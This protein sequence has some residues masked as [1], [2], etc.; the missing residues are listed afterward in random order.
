M[1]A[2]YLEIK[3]LIISTLNLEELTP[4]DIDTDAA[5]F[6]AASVWTQSTP[7]SWGWR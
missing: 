7:L 6:G 5:L 2:L 4:E 3:N 1:Q